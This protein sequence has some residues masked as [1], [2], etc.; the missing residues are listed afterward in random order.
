[1][2][3]GLVKTAWLFTRGSRSVRILRVARRGGGLRMLVQGP[4]SALETHDVDD[5]IEGVRY[6]SRV[7]RG[8]VANGYQLTD[9][10]S[11]ERRSGFERRQ[12]SRGFERRQILQ[13]V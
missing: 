3:I 10:E 2:M 5:A 8:L 6:Q 13:L 9:F 7:E 1:M 12:T 11:A 4:G